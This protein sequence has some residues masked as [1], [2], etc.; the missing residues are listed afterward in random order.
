MM[1]TDYYYYLLFLYNYMHH[2]MAGSLS[3]YSDLK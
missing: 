2:M 1:V 3:N